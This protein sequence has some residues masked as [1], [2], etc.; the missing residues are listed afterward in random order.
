[1]ATFQDGGR[2]R[3]TANTVT[4]MKRSADAR[5]CP[6]CKRGA[7]LRRDAVMRATYCYWALRC[8]VDGEAFC[9]YY[10]DWDDPSLPVEGGDE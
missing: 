5:R 4:A 2:R 1:M 9:D 8:S 7:A 10:R 6:G 3:A